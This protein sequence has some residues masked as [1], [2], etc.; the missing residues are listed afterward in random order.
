MVTGEA[1]GEEI[2]AEDKSG[3]GAEAGLG[4]TDDFETKEYPVDEA[5]Y[6]LEH[7]HSRADWSRL[8]S[9]NFPVFFAK[10]IQPTSLLNPSFMLMASIGALVVAFSVLIR[11]IPSFETRGQFELATLVRREFNHLGNGV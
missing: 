9:Q 4:T 7:G 11:S 6:A 3:A 8:L 1:G 2:I 10:V 5:F